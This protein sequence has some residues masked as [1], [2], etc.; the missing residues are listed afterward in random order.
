[1]SGQ[2]ITEAK[3]GQTATRVGLY[4][5]ETETERDIYRQLCLSAFSLLSSVFSLLFSPLLSSP[6]LYSLSIL[7]LSPSPSPLL[8][9]RTLYLQFTAMTTATAN[10]PL[11]VRDRPSWLSTA[12]WNVRRSGVGSMSMQGTATQRPQDP[13]LW[14]C[15]PGR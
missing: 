4:C 5:R 15:P 7:S 6:L 9:C 1:M 10:S 11:S 14:R 8:Q 3:V 12:C 13:P 2:G